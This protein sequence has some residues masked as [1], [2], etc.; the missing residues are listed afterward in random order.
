MGAFSSKV[1]APNRGPVSIDKHAGARAADVEVS[2]SR[3]FRIWLWASA[4]WIWVVVEVQLDLASKSIDPF[5]RVIRAVRLSTPEWEINWAHWF[6]AVVLFGPPLVVLLVGRW[7]LWF[8]RK[9]MR[10]KE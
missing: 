7:G 10:L 9:V 3:W 5:S 2:M 4:L 8:A 1:A 6:E